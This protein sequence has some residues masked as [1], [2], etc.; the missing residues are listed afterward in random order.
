VIRLFLADIAGCL[1]SPY[2]AFDLEGFGQIRAWAR[3]AEEAGSVLPRVSLMSGRS[4]G[5]VEAVTQAL[6]LHAPVLF[7]SGGGRFHLP[8]GTI[9]W[10]PAL[11]PEVERELDA[12]RAYFLTEIVAREAGFTLD[13]GK[14]AQAGIVSADTAAMARVLPAARRF[15][16]ERFPDLHPYYT[17]H[18]VDVVPAA[19]TKR[20]AVAWLAAAEGL[21]ME[22]VAFV[23]DTIGDAE[24]LGAVGWGFAPR[25]AS[26]EAKEAARTVTEGAVIE[27]VLE[28]YRVCIAH[29]ERVRA[30]AQEVVL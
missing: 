22:A 20:Q 25:N 7:E 2:R 3:E 17:A 26:D 6:D 14:R 30:G 21:P 28:A 23:G 13:Y 9:T 27:G 4:Y 24:A 5:Y 29:N 19:L 8:T 18:S 16:T 1:A 11:T 10:N 15:V 12:V